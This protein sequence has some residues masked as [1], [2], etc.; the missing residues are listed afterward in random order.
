[1]RGVWQWSARFVLLFSVVLIVGF[2]GT[3][4][5]GQELIDLT[6]H[7]TLVA[8]LLLI[9]LI[10]MSNLI[11]AALRGLQHVVL[12]QLPGSIIRPILLI[13]FILLALWLIP[14][15]RLASH[16]A[17]ILHVVATGFAL[18][19]G[20]WCLCRY[21]PKGVVKESQLRTEPA[22]WR[23]AALPLSLVSGLE[24]F[25]SYADILLLGMMSTDTEV[26]VYRAVVQMGGLVVFGLN[27]VTLVLHPYFAKLYAQGDLRTLQRVVTISARVILSFALPPVL[28]F[29]FAGGHLL[30]LI[31]GS[32]YEGGAIALSFLAIGQL[33]NAGCGSVG[34][35]LNMTGH[36]TDT[37]RGMVTAAVMNVILNLVLIPLY[38]MAGAA[39]ASAAS[40]AV[41]NLVLWK[42]VWERLKI[43]SSAFLPRR[44]Y[45]P[46]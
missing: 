16:N 39:A 4:L 34:A 6:H 38:G 29:L 10:A 30:G 9:P 1:M 21:K 40:L 31:F 7:A 28:L 37:M 43:E 14:I 5:L 15:D 3:L 27:A 44:H 36:E 26:G 13:V 12:G 33:F 23:R 18:A 35:L 2:C 8:G 41:W 45:S 22:E 42:Y 11:A 24:V 17:M 32:E 19:I 25:N 20:A 46:V